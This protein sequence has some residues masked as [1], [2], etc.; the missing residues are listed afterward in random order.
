[1]K[2]QN[3]FLFFISCCLVGLSTAHAQIGPVAQAG[4]R[5]AAQAGK[6]EQE[7]SRAV[8]QLTRSTVPPIY[9]SLTAVQTVQVSKRL[10]ENAHLET[11][12]RGVPKI[13]PLEKH[14]HRFI[15]TIAPEK[16]PHNITGN[17]FV[18]AE[19]RDGQTVL[20]GLTTA[21]TAWAS[22]QNIEI[23]FHV[24]KQVQTFP[25][26]IV[27]TSNTE[28]SNT[29]LIELPATVA[30]VALPIQPADRFPSQRPKCLI[31]YGLHQNGFVSK[32]AQQLLFSGSERLITKDEPGAYVPPLGGLVVNEQGQALGIYNIGYDLK[33]IH[34]PWMD[35]VQ[36]E[37]R[38]PSLW[39]INEII[40]FRHTNYL[41]REY[42]QPHS[43]ARVLLFDGLYVGKLEMSEHIDAI[44]IRRVGQE[45]E[46][47]PKNPF[48]SLGNLDRFIPDL[49]N[50]QTAYLAIDGG[51][52]GPYFY[53]ID[54]L[55]RTTR[56]IPTL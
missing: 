26:R 31:T 3:S 8:E 5:A 53:R 47:L 32:Q 17:G 37:L 16:Q 9:T 46:K 6:L 45:L 21:Q 23:S 13:A 7:V 15:F 50:V 41:L 19:E 11:S 38:L 14:I 52:K 39:H 49:Q 51:E 42:R 34:N 24:N 43:A 22:G 54:L 48:W 18:F 40:P 35:A 2:T 33:R 12:F 20:W 36:E 28:G 25:A 29:A 10:L 27:Q 1:M 55:S 4:A 56:K 30:N 44:Y